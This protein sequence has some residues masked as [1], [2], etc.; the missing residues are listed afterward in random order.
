MSVCLSFQMTTLDEN[1]QRITEGT[2]T[3][4]KNQIVVKSAHNWDT[5]ESGLQNVYLLRNRHFEKYFSETPSHWPKAWVKKDVIWDSVGMLWSEND[6]LFSSENSWPEMDTEDE[7]LLTQTDADATTESTALDIEKRKLL[8]KRSQRISERVFQIREQGLWDYLVVYFDQCMV[9]SNPYSELGESKKEAQDG[10]VVMGGFFDGV[11]TITLRRPVHGGAP[12]MVLDNFATERCLSD[13]ENQKVIKDMV[14]AAVHLGQRIAKDVEERQR[15]SFW[16]KAF[17][18]CP[19]PQVKDPLVFITVDTHDSSDEDD[20]V[21]SFWKDGIGFEDPTEED[22][23][24]INQTFQM[25]LLQ[26]YEH[27]S[28]RDT[29]E[30]S[31]QNDSPE[32]ISESSKATSLKVLVMRPPRKEEAST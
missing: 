11:C 10:Q 1:M 29:E 19:M 22:I 32:K 13:E 23:L 6:D 17:D 8:R 16:S 4:K 12:Y 7:P 28:A 25:P 2:V 24:H 15:D 18:P 21:A 27:F 5:M 26:D 9:E 30:V 20:A 3:A 31:V 14:M